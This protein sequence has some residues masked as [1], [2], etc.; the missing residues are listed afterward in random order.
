[1]DRKTLS[2][3]YLSRVKGGRQSPTINLLCRLADELNVE[4]YELLYFEENPQAR[5]LRRRAAKL[6]DETPDEDLARV[7]WLLEATLH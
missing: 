1:M 7:V 4:P 5:R 6:V 3:K 2:A